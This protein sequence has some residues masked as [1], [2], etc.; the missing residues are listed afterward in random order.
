VIDQ[1]T[2]LGITD[3]GVGIIGTTVGGQSGVDGRFILQ[4]VPVGTVTL[5]VRRIG[6]QAKNVDSIVVQA[7]KA[8]EQN[9]SLAVAVVQMAAV[10]VTATAERGSVAEA[11]DVQRTAVNVVSSVTQEQIT[12]SPDS[13]AA[14]AV[15]RVSAVTVRDGQHVLVRGL[16]PRYSTTELNGSRVPSPEPEKRMVP[17]DMFPSGLIQSITSA[18]TFTPDLQ[19]DFSGAIINIRT[20]E[21]P[22]ERTWAAQLSSGYAFGTTGER[23]FAGTTTGGEQFAMVN[24]RRDLPAIVRD[25]GNFQGLNLSQADKNLLA[26][27]FR[28]SWTPTSGTAL[29]NGSGSF[30]FGGSD[31]VFGRPIG[32]LLS[33]TYSRSRDRKDA[34]VRAIADRGPVAG[35]TLEIDRFEGETATESA[36]W[37][38][39]ANISTM[40]GTH[41]RIAF[42][43]LYNRTSDNTARVEQGS[44]ENEG[45]R[46]QITR[47]QYVERAVRS[48]Q[49]VGEHQ[50]GS[51]RLDWSA[52]ASGVSRDEP[53]RSEFVQAI[54]RDAGGADVLRWLSSGTGGA[55][56]TFSTLRESAH[57]G[58]ADYGWTFPAFG[59]DHLLKVGALARTTTRNADSRAFSISAPTA[60]L[61]IRELGPE[62]LFD[63]R[64][65]G[66][67]DSVFDIRA[68]A[69]GGAY[70][71]TD[72]LWATYVMSEVALGARFRVIGG[73]RYE[74]DHVALN[75]SSTLGGLVHVEKRWNDILPALALNIA[76]TDVQQVRIAVS[77]TL[78]R[79]EYRELA[80]ITSREVL[81][82]DNQEGN[83]QL[84]RTNISNADV[85][86][87]WY[88]R[89]GELFSVGV[90]AKQFDNPI[91]RVYRSVSGTRVVFYT[92]AD[93]AD[94]YGLEIEGR[95]GL[96]FLAD[97]LQPFSLFA[98]LTVMESEI[99]LDP[100]TQASATNLKRRMVGQAPY[101]VN[102]GLS[103]ASAGGGTSA[104]LLYNRIGERVDAAGDAPLPDVIEQ[105]RDVLD[106]SLRND[107]TRTVTL[108]ADAKNLLNSR[109]EIRQGSVVRSSYQTGRTFQVGFQ[110][111]P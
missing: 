49:L 110:W 72:R 30:S 96:G 1:S 75:A 99:A 15:Q 14:Q 84:K 21:Y 13:D 68:L 91:E 64:F 80:P 38:G 74:A 20:R 33:T 37:G 104:T 44:F 105:A 34:Q 42:N 6:Y 86:W 69:Q 65:F 24:N 59:A 77:R 93:R 92:N 101:V 51:H 56:R 55:V 67:T 73:A 97:R 102:V 87:E 76:L 79:P 19:G 27:Q 23:L 111:R 106:L 26:S 25:V 28:N 46:A 40:F 9:I 63:G 10:E 94:N 78:T 12:K 82:G 66:A 11:L 5:T 108:R 60:P 45:I 2:G 22:S 71:A 83:D 54:E 29:P 62:Q 89:E 85:R 52:T 3:V 39:L 81:N 48:A 4:N 90:F 7:G 109:Y 100:N 32:Y 57:E 31:P 70:D 88:P 95:K 8:V 16:D 107:L 35:T 103:Y 47:M 98:N 18:K 41:S 58:R 61:A 36:L 50:V 53:D 43:G 17:L